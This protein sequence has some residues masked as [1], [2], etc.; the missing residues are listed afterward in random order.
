MARIRHNS[1]SDGY[2]CSQRTTPGSPA[3]LNDPSSLDVTVEMIV[4]RT[5]RTNVATFALAVL[6]PN[7]AI[8]TYSVTDRVTNPL[9]I[10]PLVEICGRE[11]VTITGTRYLGE[12]LLAS[13]II[14]LGVQCIPSSIFYTSYGTSLSYCPLYIFLLYMLSTFFV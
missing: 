8:A 11:H 4:L 12:V 3:L 9:P 6:F 10:V 7:L 13:L 14:T 5:R 2:G 1:T